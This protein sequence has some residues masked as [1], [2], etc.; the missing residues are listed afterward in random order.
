[1]KKYLLLL[2]TIC[3]I[4]NGYGQALQIHSHGEIDSTKVDSIDA[5]TFNDVHSK[6]NRTDKLA[7][8]WTSGDPD[9]AANACFMYLNEAK[10]NNHFDTIEMIIWGHSTKLL[11]ENTSLQNLVKAMMQ[12]GII[13]EACKAC[14]DSYGVSGIITGLGI[15]VKY[16]GSPL[17]DMLNGDWDVICF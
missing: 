12:K 3:A 8:V 15:T 14:A 4:I 13:V 9:V 2:I 17:T 1:M 16:M 7:V 6:D 10:E 11:S 5:I